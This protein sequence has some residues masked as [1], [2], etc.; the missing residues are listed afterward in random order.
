MSAFFNYIRELFEA[1]FKNLGHFLATIFAQP[2]HGVSSDFREYRLIFDTYNYQFGGG[3]WV[4]FVIFIILLIAFFGSIGYFLYF[5]VRRLIV[6]NNRRV[7]KEKLLDEVQKLNKELFFAIQEKN[8]ILKLTADSFGISHEE[9]DLGGD[10]R[11][12]E[13]FPKLGALDM[14]YANLDTTIEVPPAD[15]GITLEQITDRF[16]RF[17]ASQLC[18]YYDMATIRTMFAAMGTSKFIIL[19]GISGTGK[20]SLPYAIGKFFKRDAVICSVQPSWRERTEMLGYFNE[21][22]KKFSETE[23]LQAIYEAAYRQ[24]PNMIILDE[25]NLAR[26]E[27]YFA[28]FLSIMEMPSV[29][30]WKVQITRTADNMNPKLLESG[31]LLISQNLW[32]VGTANNDDSTFT[33]TDKVYDRAISI[34]LDDKAEACS[35]EYTEGVSISSNDLLKLFAQAQ[36]NYPISKEALANFDK[37]D[38]LVANNFRIAFGNRILRQLRTFTSNYVAC[39][40]TEN[41]ALDFIF[42]SKVLK[43]F[44][45]LNLAFMHDELKHLSSE[46]DKLFGKGVFWQSQKLIADYLKIG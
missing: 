28:D 30:E 20:T 31:K 34:T 39:G 27:Y 43:K 23:F 16:F 21:F 5:V 38:K 35:M 10:R 8:E 18:L 19:E 4:L 15:L 12:M 29:D 36:T 46:L 44:T 37:L 3:G 22:T 11:V 13:A 6:F 7:S 42:A 2:W 41:E 26:I 24:E 40:G 14:K 32:F 33:I 25:M 17:A 45:S 1:I 9:D